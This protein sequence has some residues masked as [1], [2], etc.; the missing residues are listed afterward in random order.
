MANKKE[1][2]S[3]GEGRCAPLDCANHDHLGNHL[4]CDDLREFAVDILWTPTTARLR[5]G[6]IFSG[7]H[8]L[9]HI[10]VS[11]AAAWAGSRPLY[12]RDCA[13]GID[14]C[15]VVG[16]DPSCVRRIRRLER[17]ADVIPPRRHP[18]DFARNLYSLSPGERNSI[19]LLAE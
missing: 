10:L 6:R 19:C 4:F 14:R 16:L 8:S 13:N 3:F 12:A 9:P 11:V 18:V 1:N 17:L 5:G 7:H 2:A 15:T